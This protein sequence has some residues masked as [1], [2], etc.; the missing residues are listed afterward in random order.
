NGAVT[1]TT[2]TGGTG[3]YSFSWNTTPIQNTQ[4]ATALGFGNYTVTVKDANNC[5]T[6]ASINLTQPTALSSVT[7]SVST[8]ILCNGGSNG[9]VT[10]TTP[11]GGTGAYSFSWNTTPIQN[12]QTAT[13]LG[14]G[15]YTVT[16][17]DANNC[18][19]TASVNLTQPAVLGNVLATTIKSVSCFGGSD[20]VVSCST[21]T[22][23]TLP[24]SFRWNCIPNQFTQTATNLTAGTYTVTV[25]D[26]NNC[27]QLISNTIVNQPSASIV[28]QSTVLQNVSCYGGANGAVT[29]ATPT[30]GIPPY[31]Y[32]WNT[33]P[34]KLTQSISNLTV[35]T[36]TV[37]IKDS[38]GC[39][40]TSVAQVTQPNKLIVSIADTIDA[41]CFATSS[42]SIITSPI[43]GG[44]KPFQYSWSTTPIQHTAN[45]THLFAGNYSVI[46]ID[47]LGCSDTANATLSQPNNLQIINYSVTDVTCKTN[48]NGKIELSGITGGTSPYQI[49]W[50]S[51]PIQY[52][53]VADSLLD[54]YYIVTVKD[55]NNCTITQ[56]F[57]VNL[58]D[59]IQAIAYSDTTISKGNSFTINGNSSVGIFGSTHF[60]W[61]DVQGN[62]LA[63]TSSTTVSP[64][65]TTNYIL[66]MYNDSICKS[67]DTITVRVVDCQPVIFPN[68]FSPNGDGID[69]VFKIMNIEDVEKINRLQIYNRWGELIFATNDKNQ[70]WDGT[71][72]GKLQELDTYVYYCEVT[73][74]GGSILKTKGDVILVR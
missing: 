25:K 27:V 20:G 4:T 68:A 59:N 39:I 11:T 53:L 70:V 21:P 50:S 16:V 43:V 58:I 56:N 1:C 12:T 15:N 55:S 41:K 28:P 71:F 32:S 22:G 7:A 10:C 46:V 31:T 24:Y 42:G 44:T 36:Y 2:P 9:A 62:I 23:G 57:T 66:T 40:V 48:Q 38:L 73:C 8:S 33:S 67:Y 19:T 6:T 17:K 61:T 63:N 37:T 54:G 34:T 74:Y 14:F 47:S 13:A 60:I 51:F 65:T 64:Q 72:N 52:G 49:S 26:A 3:A 35:G 69:D 18:S 30:T 29:V 45:A 5:S